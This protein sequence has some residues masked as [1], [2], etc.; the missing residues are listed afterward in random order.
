ML[1]ALRSRM[2][3]NR[4]KAVVLYRTDA[5]Q[6]EYLAPCDERVQ[7]LSGG[8]SGSNATTVVTDRKALLWTDSRYWIQAR[9]QLKPSCRRE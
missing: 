4:V 2:R 8:F 3:A 5:H 6:S 7:A 9:K 1:T